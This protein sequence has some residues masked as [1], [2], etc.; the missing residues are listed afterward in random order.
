VLRRHVKALENGVD[1]GGL[2]P[3]V[4]QRIENGGK[5]EGDEAAFV[6]EAVPLNR[7]S[8]QKIKIIVD[9]LNRASESVREVARGFT[10]KN[11]QYFN[12][13]AD[14]LEKQGKKLDT[15]KTEGKIGHLTYVK[16][17]HE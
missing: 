17:G 5:N 15:A 6:D 11:G 1:V 13:Y 14:F 8:K 2:R 3:L 7:A 16:T 10:D 12:V 9:T 4:A